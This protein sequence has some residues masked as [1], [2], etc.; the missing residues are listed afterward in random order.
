MRRFKATRKVATAGV[1]VGLGLA[2]A[3]VA[4]AYVTATGSGSG[5]GKVATAS[6]L[7]GELEGHHQPLP[8]HRRA[9][10][11]ARPRPAATRV[12]NTT[13]GQVH[14]GTNT[15]AL[16]HTG[17]TIK[18][19]TGAKVAGCKAAWFTVSVTTQPDA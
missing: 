3:G 18:K 17:T 8:R 14:F 16:T 7:T 19:S 9:S 4:F 11:P 6:T 2:A 12:R 10:C 13:A 15:V 1:I 5:A